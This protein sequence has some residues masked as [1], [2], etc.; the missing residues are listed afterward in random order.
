[1]A[2]Y[3][4][5]SEASGLLLR[6]INLKTL[7]I[8]KNIDIY[9]LKFKSLSNHHAHTPGHNPCK[10]LLRMYIKPPV[11][12]NFIATLSPKPLQEGDLCQGATCFMMLT[13]GVTTTPAAADFA[14]K[15]SWLS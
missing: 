5:A 3:E 14:T 13:V 7:Q 8:V 2:S 6:T 10:K 9:L 11:K 1:M 15:R 4:A 12:M